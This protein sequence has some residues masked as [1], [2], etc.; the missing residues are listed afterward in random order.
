MIVNW[1]ALP[2]VAELIGAI[3]VLAS[4][5]YLGTRIRQ[6]I[7]WLRRQA[8]QLGTN[9]V[10]R[11]AS[12]LSNSNANSELFLKSQRDFGSLDPTE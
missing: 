12:N 5:I 9:E 10:R 2:A 4:L 3:G 8:F 1:D 7:V 6:N 11:W